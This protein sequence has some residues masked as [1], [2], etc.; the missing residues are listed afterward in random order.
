M[1]F[2]ELAFL[3]SLEHSLLA[4][5]QAGKKSVLHLHLFA[6]EGSYA[7]LAVQAV[8][9]VSPSDSALFPNLSAEQKHFF[10]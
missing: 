1:L 6:A 8:H 7:E 9:V 2:S 5:V 3:H 10:Y 4:D